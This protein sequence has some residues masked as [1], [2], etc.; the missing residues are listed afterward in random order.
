MFVA[1]GDAKANLFYASQH[2]GGKIRT[3]R[4]ITEVLRDLFFA[5]VRSRQPR[6]DR[7][8]R[9]G[10]LVANACIML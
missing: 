8:V 3:S 2:M 10:E 4:L 5:A 7:H 1:D 6:L 9:H